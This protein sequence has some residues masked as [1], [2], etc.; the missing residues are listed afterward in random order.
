VPVHLARGRVCPLP[1]RHER[2]APQRRDPRSR[3]HVLLPRLQREVVVGA[4]SQPPGPRGEVCLVQSFLLLR[5]APRRAPLSA[6]GGGAP[7]AAARRGGASA[8]GSGR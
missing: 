7:R 4:I 8:R 5:R 3:R 1:L 2:R 6:A